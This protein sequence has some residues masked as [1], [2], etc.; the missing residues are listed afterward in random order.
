MLRLPVDAELSE[1]SMRLALDMLL[2]AGDSAPLIHLVVAP[3][4]RF[5]AERL[6]WSCSEALPKSVLG[7]M[8][9]SGQITV[10]FAWGGAPD[11]WMM[12]GAEHL[13]SSGAPV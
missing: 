4:K 10:N 9:R 1:S 12:M 6:L 7:M 11:R 5:L 13:I 3:E 2:G 8:S